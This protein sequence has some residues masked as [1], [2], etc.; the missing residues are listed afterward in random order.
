ME[1]RRKLKDKVFVVTYDLRE[2]GEQDYDSISEVLEDLGGRRI[3]KSVWT[4]KLPGTWDCSRL[5]NK[6][7]KVLCYEDGLYVAEV[8]WHGSFNPDDEPHDID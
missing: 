2:G 6:L 1:Y 3:L 5:G 4:V 7:L 8:K